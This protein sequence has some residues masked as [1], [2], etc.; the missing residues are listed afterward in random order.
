MKVHYFKAF[1]A[2]LICLFVVL[3]CQR[4]QAAPA[5]ST[6]LQGFQHDTT[7]VQKAGRLKRHPKIKDN[8]E[9]EQ[10]DGVDNNVQARG[11]QEFY[12]K[13]DPK[14]NRVPV[15]RLLNARV[16]RDMFLQNVKRRPK[17]SPLNFIKTPGNAPLAPVA[18]PT[19][20]GLQWQERGPNNVGGR[21][22]ALMFDKADSLNG[23]KRV[24]AGGVDG[25]LWVTSDITATTIQWTKINDFMDNLAISCIAQNPVNPKEIYA[26]TGEGFL[27]ADA[28]Q[29]LGVWK[30]TDGGAT[31]THIAGTEPFKFINAILVDR[32]SNVYIAGETDL[33][34][35]F[36]V[37]KSSNGGATWTNVISSSEAGADLQLAANGD[38]YASTGV[39]F[40]SGHVFISDFAAH[41]AN[42][43]NAG[44]WTNITPASNGVIT[45]ATTSWDRIKLALA[46]SD[47]NVVYAFME[48]DQQ[49]SL[50]SVQV[51]NKATNTW[52]VRA[53]PSEAFGNGQAWYSIAAAVDPNNSSVLYAGSLDAERSTDGGQTWTRYTFWNNSPASSNYVHADHHAYVY[54]PGSSSRLMMGTDGGVFYTT[55]A[56]AT[57]PS[58]IN[59]NNGYN[60]TQF[61]SVALHPTNLNYALAGAQDN[62]SEKF[63]SAGVGPTTVATGGDGADVFIDQTN[64]NIQITSYVYDQ[65]YLSTNNGANFNALSGYGNGQ[66][67]NP[68]DYDPSTKTI[69]AGSATGYYYR[70]T[71]ITTSPAYNEVGVPAFGAGNVNSVTV[72]P[73]TAN[74]VYFG[75]DNGTVVR[76]DNAQTGTS[77]TGVVLKPNGG[78]P[79]TMVSWVAVDPTSEDHI[80]VTYSNYGISHVFETKNASA[81]TPTWTDVSGN[82]PDMPVRSAIFYPGD[83]TKAIIATELGV[84]TT[85]LINGAS[86]TWDPNNSG[87][88][89]V[90][91]DMLKYR[92]AD[93]TLAAATH[94]RG[95]FTTNL[96]SPTLSALTAST[97]TL[98]PAFSTSTLAY[99]ETVPYATTQITVTPTAT[100]P[101]ATITVNGTPVT[102]GS[103][104]AAI[105]LSVGSNI[106]NIAVSANGTTVTYSITVTRSAASSNALL[107]TIATTPAASLL[108][109]TGSGYLNFKTT[110][111]NSFSSI[112][113]IPTAQDPT[114]TI[115]VNGTAVVSGTASQ[116]I[117]L[118]VGQTVITIILTAQN[119]VATKTVIVT[120]T[121]APSAV[122]T[123]AG[124]AL[125]SGTLTPAF[126]STTT[127]YTASVND[128]ASVTLTPTVTDPT[129]TITVNGTA[130]TSGVGVPVTLVKGANTITTVVT[131]QDGTTKKTYTTTVTLVPGTNALIG[132]IATLP[133]TS[134]LTT[135]GTGYLNF[136]ATVPNSISSIQVVPTAKDA[137]ATIAV[138]GTPVVSGTASQS[139]ALPVGQTLITTVITAQDAVT[140]KSVTITVTRAASTNAALSN[141]ALSTGTLTPVFATGT[142]NYTASVSNAM[143]SIKITPTA[144][145]PTASIMVNG[146]AVA[147]GVASAPIPLAV[148][149]NTITTVVTAQDGVTTK[150]YTT[151]VTRISNNALLGTIAT[152]PAASLLTTTGTGYLNFK[153]T[154]P[155]STA[156][157]QVVPT[158]KDPTATITVNGTAVVSGAASQTI[159]LPVGQTVITT[160]IT[161]QDG[162][163]T[164]TVILTVTRAPSSN[165]GLSNIAL[166][167]GTLSPAFAS[168]ITSY[169]ATVNDIGSVTFTP[170]TADAG[171]TLT[172]NG[173]PATSGTGVPVTLVKGANIIT[174]VVTAQDGTTKKTYTTTVTLVPGTNAQIATI[175][176]TP[177]VSLVGTT[178]TGYLNFKASVPNS[179]SSI[180]EVVTL[181][182]PLAT[183][184]VNGTAVASGAA[185]Q[186]IALPVGPTVITTVIT[187]QD[188]VTQ[189]T[190]ILTVTRA[191]SSN[192]GLSN[193]TLSAGTLTP[194]F[195]TSTTN[196]K[197]SVNDI[198]MVN[199]TPTTA[200]ATATLAINGMAATSGTPVPFHLVNG[201]NTITTVVTAQDGTT[202]KTY[203]TTV[204]LTP[205]TNAQIATIATTPTV[206]LVGTTG[207]GYL[208]FKANVANSVS[209][210]QEIVTL[211][212]PVATL[213]VNGTAATSGAPSQAIP[214]AVGANV[215]T[216]VITAQDGVTQ[217]TVIVTVTR[218]MP[219]IANPLYQSQLGVNKPANKL[220]LNADGI[221]VHQALS[222]NGDGINDYLTIEGITKYPDNK[223]TII[224]RNGILVYEKA[225]YDNSSKVFDG[226]SNQGKMQQ[227]GTYF[228]SLDYKVNGEN[229]HL[230]GYILLRY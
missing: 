111:P 158:A 82:L 67:I 53:V 19:I 210:I 221:A 142:L 110:V 85:D 108:T 145:D 217:K 113:V 130:A 96:A 54:F 201:V 11:L 136:K 62:G 17:T 107:S 28:V 8:E 87:L 177:V 182:D 20:A 191:P 163:T 24:F 206:T 150:T 97:G 204:T 86:T 116:S 119:G 95:L 178:G 44:T 21:T 175:A 50:G 117:A 80:L 49:T 195:V 215:I 4:S 219:Q 41:G 131:A 122:A 112:Q 170:T 146:T 73:I 39:Y 71:N 149:N 105:P 52:T 165:A 127:S 64:G 88:A 176:T 143:A 15:E 123:L 205:G 103:A 135:T 160:I 45:P 77:N 139:I 31:W 121:R 99:T 179:F 81:A 26:G 51:Y 104:S 76:V 230:T 61:Y 38:V 229:R 7:R 207:T 166:S 134:L 180:Q 228:Y 35:G 84:W 183:M 164:K 188:G 225:G 208:N 42:T 173:T 23:Y 63:S 46:P 9:K 156:S 94:G 148:G 6:A 159:A 79:S 93:Q 153:T 13:R 60:V 114:A 25:G 33:F 32:N 29:G 154:V 174:T 223:L 190:V 186:S 89:N 78:I 12:Q 70:A 102:S 92:A 83:P 129:A 213:T 203:T 214:L 133:A 30:S 10:E 132:T 167:I 72:A 43:G 220:S 216:T 137:T 118:P 100:S 194:A 74:R 152:L 90:E 66:F 48:T 151:V 75:L 193:L 224:D 101:T 192:A 68:T 18:P 40:V 198:G 27:N 36:G 218:A 16:K 138:N 5:S 161:A 172:V 199:I 22:R 59:R 169:S 197:A 147:S 124:I 209:S 222:P 125:S 65:Y 120:V 1:Y 141:L 185:S 56:N 200:D 162:V 115:T 55:N 98:S 14:L 226:H 57:P 3:L 91:V 155:N 126:V 128:L 211:K 227:P 168:A 37:E 106:I 2:G 171:A 144:A 140:T 69:Y 202:Q 109:T 189:K 184:T 157:I 181:K 212:D 58:F 34:V 187:A 47:A 196:Y